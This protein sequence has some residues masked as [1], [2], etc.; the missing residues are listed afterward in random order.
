MADKG[1]WC[2][3]RPKNPLSPF[4]EESYNF[5]NK[6][7]HKGHETRY[8]RL[9]CPI[10]KEGV[11]IRVLMLSATPVNNRLADLKNQVAFITEGDDTA[12]FDDGIASIEA[13]VRQRSFSS[14]GGWHST[15]PSV[16]PPGSWTCWGSTT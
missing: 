6:S 8:D 3:P 11:K 2:C 14:I 13:T 12:L 1:G 7:A 10:I 5:R 9:M 16:P 15:T 4:F